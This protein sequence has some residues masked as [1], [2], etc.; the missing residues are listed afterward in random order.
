M[1]QL[2]VLVHA[3]A[4]GPA[5]WLPV[6]RELSAA[7]QTAVVP[8]LTGFADGGP[9]YAPRLAALVA[10]QVPADLQDPVV[11]VTHSGAGVLAAQLS[12]AIGASDVTAIFADA[13]L[14]GRG[15]AGPIL[16]REFLPYLREIA[17][18]G[19]VPPWHQWWPDEDLSPLFPGEPARRAV[20][21]EARSIPL[22]F[23]E[24]KLPPVPAHWPPRRAGYLLFS[25]AYRSQ[26]R[27]AAELGW[28]VRELPGEHLHM[29]VDPAGVAAA[30]MDLAREPLTT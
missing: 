16:D 3:P 29:L 14:P 17:S 1:S 15:G 24:E 25:E 7:G 30:I 8:V 23:F 20:T 18:D 6:A 9:P 22:A 11:L 28:P 2:F 19:L 26:A 27:L 5:S 12:A 13:G 4:L 21:G 10:G